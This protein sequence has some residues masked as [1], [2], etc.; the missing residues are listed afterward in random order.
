MADQEKDKR[1]DEMLDS[2]LANYSAAEPRP[3]LETRILAN[4]RERP[5]KETVQGW[6]NF[7]W[8]WAGMVT[9]AIIIAAVLMS[10]R[11]PIEPPANVIV[12]N[13]QPAAQPQ[14]QPHAPIAPKETARVYWRKPRATKQPQDAALALNE[15]P[16]NFPTPTP[17]S[18][19]ERMMFTY[20]ANTPKE[21]VIAQIPRNND[22]KE[23]EEFWA[24]REPAQGTRRST[25]DR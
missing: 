16:A 1:I 3:G 7:K 17:L 18:E 4:L 5:E 24:D 6:W 20:L 22:E 23:G 8:I 15:R 10:V 21:I 14:I 19:Q 13:N 25:T 9:A 11:R 2:L 12:K